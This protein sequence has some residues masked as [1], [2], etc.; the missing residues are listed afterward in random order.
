ML[1]PMPGPSISAS[2]SGAEL[3]ARSPRHRHVW[4]CRDASERAGGR[5]DCRA[6]YLL[7]AALVPRAE[8]VTKVSAAGRAQS[9]ARY[10][11]LTK[12]TL[13]EV[14]LPAESTL[15]SVY[16][17]DQPTKPQREPREPAHQPVATRATGGAQSFQ[18]VYES[19]THSLGLAGTIDAVAPLLLVR[20]AGSDESR[21]IPQADLQWQ[22]ILPSSYVVR[23]VGGTVATNELPIQAGPRACRTIPLRAGR[24]HSS[25]ASGQPIARRL[26]C[27]HRH[28]DCR[29]RHVRFLCRAGCSQSRPG[30]DMPTS[31]A[32]QD[33]KHA[34][35]EDF[36]ERSMKTEIA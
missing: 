35:P 29:S 7:P 17:D 2:S 9:V 11:L 30:T 28:N 18:I 33:G 5:S 24:R 23:R 31:I 3:P 10:D 26:V 34:R 1:R 36:S 19:P 4:L 14:R 25:V 15:W 20:A 21:E 32:I 27:R 13:L 6:A 16:Q 8:L 12:A 22:L